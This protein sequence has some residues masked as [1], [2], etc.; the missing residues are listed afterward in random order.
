MNILN[1]KKDWMYKTNSSFF[2][3]QVIV[4]VLGVLGLVLGKF[5]LNDS[6][7]IIYEIHNN[8]FLIFSFATIAYPIMVLGNLCP[9]LDSDEP[10]MKVNNLPY[11]KK[12]LFRM[13]LYNNILRI[14]FFLLITIFINALLSTENISLGQKIMDNLIDVLRVVFIMS[15]VFFQFVV[16]IV[17]RLAKGFSLVKAFSSLI[18]GNTILIGIIAMLAYILKIA[19]IEIDMFL[20]IGLVV[21]I[22]SFLAFTV[23][24]K[25]IEKIN[26]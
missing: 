11:S 18:V 14:S 24:W 2:Y 1:T 3:V 16:V 25:D 17:L 20:A 8:I 19:N 4:T 26:N 9:K 5:I 23:A 21:F 7:S 15:V 22:G 13:E 10:Y 6:Q 12:Q